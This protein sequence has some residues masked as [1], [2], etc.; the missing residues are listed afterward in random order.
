MT[1]R[2]CCVPRAYT[3]SSRRAMRGSPRS[4]RRTRCLS[5]SLSA[6]LSPEGASRALVRLSAMNACRLAASPFAI[7]E[8][9]RNVALKRTGRLPDL[10]AMLAFVDPVA[11]APS[12]LVAWARRY[13]VSKDTPILAAAVGAR[14]AVLV[15][16]DRRHVGRLFRVR[17]ARHADRAACGRARNR[18]GLA[19]RRRCQRGRKGG[20]DAPSPSAS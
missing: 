10:A 1:V 4:W 6:S 16:G 11:D 18:F 17:L 8:P 2:S 9:R 15:T 7:D 5:A 20:R 19:R 14:A 12:A 3:P 13:V